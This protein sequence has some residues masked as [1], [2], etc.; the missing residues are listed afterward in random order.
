MV[1]ISHREW[2]SPLGPPSRSWMV[3]RGVIESTTFVIKLNSHNSIKDLANWERTDGRTGGP[4]GVVVV[5]NGLVIF[6]VEHTQQP[7]GST[8]RCI[9]FTKW[10]WSLIWISGNNNNQP[11]RR[12]HNHHTKTSILHWKKKKVN[13]KVFLKSCKRDTD[14]KPIKHLIILPVGRHFR[15]GRGSWQMG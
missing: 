12:Q 5:W 14:F 15:N 9:V 6:V 4:D 2:N 7:P 3:E 10:N 11:S 1:L 13:Y 8:H